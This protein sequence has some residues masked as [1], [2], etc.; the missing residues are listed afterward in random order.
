MKR[1]R[2]FPETTASVPKA[3]QFVVDLLA[4]RVPELRDTAS[5]LVSELATNALLHAGS[6]FAVTVVY[7]TPSGRV[8]IEVADSDRTQPEP[9]EPPSSAPHG[10]GLLLVSTMSDEW[11]MQPASRRAGKTIWFELTPPT[12]TAPATAGAAGAT[13]ARASRWNLG[14]RSTKGLTSSFGDPAPS[15]HPA[16]LFARMVRCAKLSRHV[17]S[18]PIAC[19]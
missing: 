17:R 8:R 12:A 6:D 10:R 7:P 16:P 15:S 9:L 4:E 5:L 13:A 18:S 11:G 2:S 1:S 3:R 14:R 19:V